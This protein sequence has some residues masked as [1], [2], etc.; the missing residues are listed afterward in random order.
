MF[1]S[2]MITHAALAWG[3]LPR[4]W[5]RYHGRDVTYGEHG[6][7]PGAEGTHRVGP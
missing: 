5:R 2:S 6:P 4:T 7:A 3:R 1:K